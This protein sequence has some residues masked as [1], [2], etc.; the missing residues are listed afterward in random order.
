L[1]S[2]AVW[3][4][5]ARSAAEIPVVTPSRASIV[6]VNAVWS[7]VSLC[8]VIGRSESSSQRAGVRQRQIRPRAWVAMK[9]IASGVANWAA[10][11]RSPSFSR[12]AAS[13]TTTNLPS[14]TSRIASSTVENAVPACV[15]I[16]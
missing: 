11:V 13:T 9:L 16:A 3:I 2:I 5:R 10:I 12:S 7:G 1:G 15:A 14:R 8:S 4:V 6:T